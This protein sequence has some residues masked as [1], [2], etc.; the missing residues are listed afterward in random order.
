MSCSTRWATWFLG[1]LALL[2]VLPALRARALPRYA[3][4][5]E[6]NCALCHVNPGGGGMRSSYASQDLVPKEFA[7]SPAT[8]A[9]LAM[10]D[11]HIGK[12]VT[13]G[14]DFRELLILS[15]TNS[16]L[17]PPQGFFPM[18]GD[19]YL[20]LQLDPKYLLYYDRGLSN[21]YEFFG[22]AHVLPW[23]G[24][25]KAGRFV[26]PYGWKFDDHT[27]YVRNDLG[28]APPGNSDG[29][30]E[31][32]FSKRN[33]EFQ[34]ALV[35]GSR[36]STLDDDRRLATSANLSQ[37]FRLGRVSASAGVAAY[38]HPGIAEDL[39]TA[40]LF[41]YLTGWNVTWVGEGDLVRR[42]PQPGPAVTG[43]VTSHELSVLLQQGVELKATYD[44]YD[45]DRHLRTGSRSR[46]GLGAML[47]PRP[48]LSL[49]LSLRF[50][51]VQPGPVLSGRDFD[52]GIIQLHLLY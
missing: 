8:P 45:P 28:L 36:G 4:R 14:T 46:W 5:Y 48:F 20:S 30:V 44:F 6:Q 49:E 22:L 23:D 2:S 12:I 15:T 16:A 47:M 25:V 50:T 19:V 37:R 27:M 11:T 52:E 29:G 39:N 21:T 24:Y 9:A 51:D 35:N 33:T 13:I 42:D 41:G 1:T 10:L 34:I 3:A 18:Q 31:L 43:V 40:G 7:M 26:P 32:G 17:A 38:S